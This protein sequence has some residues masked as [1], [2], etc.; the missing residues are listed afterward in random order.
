MGA[1]SLVLSAWC[2]YGN[3]NK[4]VAVLHK[5]MLLLGARADIYAC[6]Q[7]R[8]CGFPLS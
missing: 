3:K 6:E 1:S 8:N 4:E 5:T 2:I 7:P